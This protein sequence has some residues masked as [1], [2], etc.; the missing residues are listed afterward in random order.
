MCVKHNSQLLENQDTLKFATAFLTRSAGKDLHAASQISTN[1]SEEPVAFICH[2]EGGGKASGTS[3]TSIPL[4]LLHGVTPQM[5]LILTPTT[6]WDHVI[7][8]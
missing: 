4:D 6:Y 2:S 3:E 5:T 8:P 1:G 7:A